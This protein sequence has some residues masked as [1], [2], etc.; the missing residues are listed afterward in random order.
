MN[1]YL[2]RTPIQSKLFGYIQ[3]VEH[4]SSRKYFQEDHEESSWEN[5]E[6]LD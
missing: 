4:N 3:G 6:K 2:L 5:R 1:R